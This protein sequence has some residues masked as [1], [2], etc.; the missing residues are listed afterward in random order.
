MLGI[1]HIIIEI[2]LSLNN[3]IDKKSLVRRRV[4]M[5][6][7]STRAFGQL[8]YDVRITCRV[9][10]RQQRLIQNYNSP[11]P[12]TIWNQAKSLAATIDHQR[13]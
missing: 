10:D 13:H 8:T 9:R 1:L 6:I 2:D 11:V 3:I 4:N 7:I 5:W 12:K